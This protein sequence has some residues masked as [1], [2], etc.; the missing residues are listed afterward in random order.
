MDTKCKIIAFITTVISAINKNIQE[1]K[2]ME[3]SIFWKNFK[4][5]TEL[6][7]ESRQWGFYE[8]YFLWHVKEKTTNDIW[9]YYYK[10]LNKATG[11]LELCPIYSI[12]W[13]I[14]S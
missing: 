10:I 3:H 12:S 14:D 5:W 13:Y 6:L 2:D 9:N 11:N 1:H 8:W 4:V 7:Y